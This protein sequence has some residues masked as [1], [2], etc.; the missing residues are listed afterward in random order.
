[1]ALLMKRNLYR[2]IL[3]VLCMPAIRS[4]VDWFGPNKEFKCH[5]ESS[6]S[7]DGTCLGNG[8][9]A[10]GWFGLKCQYK[11]LIFLDKTRT[12]PNVNILT[13]RDDSTCMNISD[14]IVIT[15]QRTDIF[16]WM[17]VTVQE[18]ASLPGFTLQFQ[19]LLKPSPIECLNQKY[20]LVDE[21]TLDIQCDLTEAFKAVTITAT[22]RTS[23]CSI[24]INGGRNVALKQRA[25]QTSNWANSKG[26]YHA[27][28]AVDGNTD[29]DFIRGQSC[30]HTNT[31]GD[32]HPMWSVTFP[33]AQVTGYVI[34]NRYGLNMDRLANF[35]LV[36]GDSGVIKFFYNDN[37]SGSR[38]HI[39]KDLAKNK[40]SEVN[41]SVSS[42]ILSLCEVEVYGECPSGTFTTS[43]FQCMNCPAACPNSCHT[44]AGSCYVHFYYSDSPTCTAESRRANLTS[45]NS[46][47][48]RKSL[49]YSGMESSSIASTLPE[50]LGIGITIGAVAVLLILSV[51]YA[52]LEALTSTGYNKNQGQQL[53]KTI[54]EHN[55]PYQ[56][57]AA[58]GEV[59]LH[60]KVMEESIV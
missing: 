12:L 40:I 60:H 48:S 19:T 51:S 37:T 21:S 5:C 20:F 15:L 34:F 41:I 57:S 25:W 9:C 24:Y 59:K 42:N 16:T 56:R 46:S 47:T 28:R 11:D 17:R 49:S 14:Q 38:F 2:C 33:L 31:S 45:Y 55:H 6:C 10:R 39:I 54:K 7:Y 35:I 32:S 52:V 53:S 29:Y 22:Q 26:T 43:D 23:L 30:S 58:D 18:N 8:K 3:C 50:A 1:M 36:A 13:D 27:S 4:Q 44:N